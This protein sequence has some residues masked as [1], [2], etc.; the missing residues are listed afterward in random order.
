MDLDQYGIIDWEY[1]K[2][3]YPEEFFSEIFQI[4]LSQIDGYLDQL[5]FAVENKNQETFKMQSHG[6]KGAA[7]NVGA[8]KLSKLALDLEQKAGEGD[9]LVTDKLEFLTLVVV[10]TKRVMREFIDG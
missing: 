7:A 6:I 9:F 1:L 4:F 3:N 5:N 10:E 2:G 8:V